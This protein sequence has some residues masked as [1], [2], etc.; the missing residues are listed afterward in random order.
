LFFERDEVLTRAGRPCSVF[1]A[2]RDAWRERLEARYV[3]AS[4]VRKYTGAL[5]LPPA[6]DVPTLEQM[7]F[8]CGTRQKLL[9]PTGMSDSRVR[10]RDFLS[11]VDRYHEQR[12]YP[13][14]KGPSH[15]S[16]HSRFGIVSIRELVA[17][18]SSDQGPGAQTWLSE[19]IWREFYFMIL[20][21]HPRIVNR[22]FR[23]ELDAIRFPNR[24]D[25]FQAWCEGRT[26]YPAM[27]QINEIGY[28]HNRVRMVVASFPVK[29]LRVDWRWVSATLRAN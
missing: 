19:L 14:L 13:A 4:P 29:D 17:A 15:L 6:R 23:A 12:E 27:R 28:M 16:V 1:S 8:K 22:A 7:G 10:L 21:H 24:E 5:A 20:H 3:A 25:W 11:R 9:L 26:G 2:Y 18:A